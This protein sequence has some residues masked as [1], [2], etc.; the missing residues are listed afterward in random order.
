I[1]NK[2]LILNS[3][4]S[5]I[6]I[7]RNYDFQQIEMTVYSVPNTWK[8]SHREEVAAFGDPR[9]NADSTL[10][11]AFR[12]AFPLREVQASQPT[13]GGAEYTEDVRSNVKCTNCDV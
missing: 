13:G 11:F 6:T 2:I 7:Y 8:M 4:K 9:A 12:D 1:L 3:D 5:N 10:Q